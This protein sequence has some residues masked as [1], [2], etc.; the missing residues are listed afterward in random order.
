MQKQKTTTLITILLTWLTL[1]G[2]AITSQSIFHQK[3]KPVNS[4]GDT[5]TDY[6][7]K[8]E[9]AFE[10]KDYGKA[11]DFFKKACDMGD[12]KGCNNLGVMYMNGLGV[13]KDY[14]KAIE[15]YSKACNMGDVMGCINMDSLGSK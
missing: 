11:F 8:G 4:Y 6:F 10:E 2:C 13:G 15:L 14:H 12:A 5:G 1:H 7:M 3:A 9:E